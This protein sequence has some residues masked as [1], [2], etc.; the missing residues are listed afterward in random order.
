MC[1]TRIYFLACKTSKNH[2]NV[3]DLNKAVVRKGA[4]KFDRIWLKISVL[5]KA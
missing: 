3:V 2:Y 1:F 5:G 4:K